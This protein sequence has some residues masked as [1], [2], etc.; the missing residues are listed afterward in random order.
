MIG[1]PW[2]SQFGVSLDLI[3]ADL[4]HPLEQLR[5]CRTTFQQ[6]LGHHRLCHPVR[7]QV[8]ISKTL[9]HGIYASKGITVCDTVA[10]SSP[11]GDASVNVY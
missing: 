11:Y 4:Q 1:L 2:Y 10:L 3:E 5:T 6:C 8:N 7:H 9:T